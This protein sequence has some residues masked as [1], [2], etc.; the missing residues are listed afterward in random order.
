[1]VDVST[2]SPRAWLPVK[3]TFVSATA[4]L[5]HFIQPPLSR[6][7]SP[8]MGM[9]TYSDGGVLYQFIYDRDEEN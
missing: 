3:I 2:T 5:A 6:P 7:L 4:W 1:M 9:G 8:G